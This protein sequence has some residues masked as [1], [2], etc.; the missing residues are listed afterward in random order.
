M[1]T[2]F[3]HPPFGFALFY[4]RGIA[5]TLFKDGRIP[6]RV[7]SSDIYL[8]SIPWVILQLVLVAIV[9]CVPQTVMMFRDAPEQVDLDKVNIEAPS[10]DPYRS[11]EDPMQGMEPAPEPAPEPDAPASDAAPAASTP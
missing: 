11:N 2:S 3:M 8:G 1:Q 4:L 7:E 9:I 10:D 6:K 5:D